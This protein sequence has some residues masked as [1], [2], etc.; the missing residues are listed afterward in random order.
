MELKCKNCGSEEF[1]TRPNQYDI[2]KF[3]DG[4]LV[5]QNS[6]VTNNEVELFCRECSERIDF[7]SCDLIGKKHG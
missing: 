7:A 6:E 4:K 3:V 5:F 1:I 2:Y